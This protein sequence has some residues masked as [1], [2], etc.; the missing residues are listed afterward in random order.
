MSCVGS[1][2]IL[3]DTDVPRLVKCLTSMSFRWQEL[4]IALHLPHSV[5]QQCRSS[6]NILSLDNILS[7]WVEGQGLQPASLGQL[8]NALAGDIV[9][10]GRL[11]GDLISEFNKVLEVEAP[12]SLPE[13]SR[14][15]EL[16]AAAL[17][18]ELR[19]SFE[20]TLIYCLQVAFNGNNIVSLYW[21]LKEYGLLIYN[22][23]Q[24]F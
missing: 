11:A 1:N 17:D 24:G 2:Y 3:K 16:A 5:R 22:C 10:R 12:P 13:G 21:L 8:V 15:H 23:P 19:Y 7:E 6:R 4:G 20:C 18:R 9:G 14:S